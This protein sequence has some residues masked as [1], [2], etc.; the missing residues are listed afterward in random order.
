MPETDQPRAAVPNPRQKTSRRRGILVASLL[1][2]GVIAF[3]IMAEDTADVAQR[4]TPPTHQLVSVETLSTGAEAVEVSAFAHVNPRWAAELRAAVSGRITQ[5]APSALAG[6]QVSAGT[7]LVT[8][9]NSQYTAEMADAELAVLQAELDLRKAKSATTVAR[10][11]F[12]RDGTKPPSDLSIHL[13]EQAIAKSA[14]KSAKARLAAARQQLDDATINSPFSGFVTDRFVSLGQTVNIGDPLLKLVDDSTFELKVALSKKDWRLLKHPIA[15]LEARVLDTHDRQIATARIRRGG[16]FLDEQT[17]Q[18]QVF[19]DIQKTD[20]TTVLSGDFVRVVL[21]G[22]TLPDTLNIAAS[23]LTQ[24]GY[25]WHL[26]AEDRLQKS[27]VEVLFH[28]HTRIIVR[29]PAA[30]SSWRVA[31]SPL[32]SYLPGQQVQA[33]TIEH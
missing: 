19:L 8:I 30:S 31:V 15:G 18:Y 27:P 29:A 5:V 3:L 2:L 17:R 10:R 13:P 6:E 20:A 4:D 12:Q 21:P 25:I 33:Q 7:T 32:A 11:Q 14:V 23:S 16:G 24:D 26:D 9:E 1:L 28:R 22:K